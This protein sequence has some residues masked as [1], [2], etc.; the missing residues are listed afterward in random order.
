MEGGLCC[1]ASLEEPA[2]AACCY[3]ALYSERRT[4]GIAASVYTAVR[5]LRQ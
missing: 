1:C 4:A 3:S 2:G 5:A